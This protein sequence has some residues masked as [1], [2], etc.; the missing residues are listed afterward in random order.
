MCT[1][2]GC[3]AALGGLG[4]FDPGDLVIREAELFAA[5]LLSPSLQLQSYCPENGFGFPE[6]L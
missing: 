5:H 4:Q 3:D 2:D 6:F 1:I